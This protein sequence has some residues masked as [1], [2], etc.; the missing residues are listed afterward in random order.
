LFFFPGILS[1]YEGQSLKQ[2]SMSCTDA[3]DTRKIRGTGDDE[4]D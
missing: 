4:G 3:G 2:K 1:D